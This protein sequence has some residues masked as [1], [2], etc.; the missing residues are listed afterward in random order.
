[1]D[2]TRLRGVTTGSSRTLTSM[3]VWESAGMQGMPTKSRKSIAY[4]AQD[5]SSVD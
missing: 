5:V 1:M 4:I 3:T 2:L